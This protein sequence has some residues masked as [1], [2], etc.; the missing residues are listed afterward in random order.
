MLKTIIV[1]LDISDLSERVIE[2]LE[3]LQIESK[4]KIVLSHVLPSPGTE[5]D[6]TVDRP[7]K[8]QEVLYRSIEKQLHSYQA[9]LACETESEIV[10]GDP[11]EEIIRL[12]NIYKAD[13]IV[14]GTR[15]LKGVKRIIEG[16]VSSQVVADSIC[17]VL[18]VKPSSE[19]K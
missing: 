18:V 4:T 3:T 19:K 11:A 10:S 5:G 6:L 9:Q 14:I 16:S 2:A 8:S 12:A 17:S 13:L 15:G 7:H 1:A